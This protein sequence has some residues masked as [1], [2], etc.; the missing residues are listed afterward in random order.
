MVLP[1]VRKSRYTSA[2][3]FYRGTRPSHEHSQTYHTQW[4]V[5]VDLSA[6]LPEQ[7]KKRKEKEILVQRGETNSE[8]KAKKKMKELPWESF[9]LFLH[10]NSYFL[11]RCVQLPLL[12]QFY[13]Q[14]SK[15]QNGYLTCPQKL[16]S[17]KQTV[18]LL[19]TRHIFRK[20]MKEE[21]LTNTL[22]NK[23]FFCLQVG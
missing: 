4:W 15:I 2:D 8:I 18:L 23:L 6:W 5:A 11:Y 22:T 19:R 16:Y 14:P 10:H 9:S 13:R 3:C 12:G 17:K 21:G 1:F 20:R 7:N